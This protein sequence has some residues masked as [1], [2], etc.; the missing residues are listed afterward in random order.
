L[1]FL[2]GQGIGL[3]VQFGQRLG[4]DFRHSGKTPFSAPRFR[5]T[6]RVFREIGFQFF[7][8][9]SVNVVFPPKFDEPSQGD[10]LPNQF[11]GTKTEAGQPCL[12]SGK[13]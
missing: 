12:T 2:S 5:A 3:V 4:Q 6:L 8:T 10:G 13:R 9:T 11:I 7:P 1:A